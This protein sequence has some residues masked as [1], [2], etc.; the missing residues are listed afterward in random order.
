[1]G[2]VGVMRPNVGPLAEL[3]QLAVA[4][5]HRGQGLRKLMG[6]RLGEEVRRLGLVGLFGE[7]VT[8][9][10]ISQ[11]A[12]DSRGLHVT[13]I[14]LLDWQAQFKKLRGVEPEPGAQRE[15]MVYYFKYLIP[16]APALV[17]APSR[18]REVLTRIYDNLEVP[19]ELLQP[20]GPVGHG[21]VT[22]HYDRETGGGT[23]QVNRIGMDTLPEIEQAQRD[24]CDL[25]GAAVVGLNLPLAQ[26]TTPY[27]AD[28]AEACGFFFS[29][30]LP[31]S[32]ADGDFLR[33]QYLN[34]ELDLE[35]LHLSSPFARELLAYVLK[36]KERVEQRRK[37]AG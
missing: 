26:G 18:H 10:T 20:S 14:K 22:V 4:P 3:G 13:A 31:H 15:S 5:A 34:A 21:E 36:D 24:L 16:P 17:C 35:R 9:H 28:A 1:V 2:H 37:K 8:I 19:R 33:M 25:A 12:S 11:E 7:A 30:V 32:A 23:I 29:G 6:D 27:L